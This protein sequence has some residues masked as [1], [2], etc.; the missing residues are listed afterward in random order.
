MFAVLK[1]GSYVPK[2]EPSPI[3]EE[4]VKE[5]VQKREEMKK[6]EKETEAK[7]GEADPLY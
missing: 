1:D 3:P 7:V 5:R 6:K 2:R 4:L